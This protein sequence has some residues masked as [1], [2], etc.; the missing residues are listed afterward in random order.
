MKAAGGKQR[1]GIMAFIAIAS[2]L[3]SYGCTQRHS[4][5]P[6]ADIR[7]LANIALAKQAS[8][9]LPKVP[10]GNQPCQSLSQDEQKQIE[11]QAQGYAMPV[12]GKPER[13][14]ANLPFDNACIYHDFSVGYMS[15]G[16]YVFNRDGNHSTEH[17]DPS[18]LP[19]AFYGKQDGVWFKK[20]GY[21]V[22]V[23]GRHRLQEP[24]AKAIAAKL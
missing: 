15:Q 24:V 6:R 2:L 9:N 11:M 20:N 12:P 3:P 7:S 10:F 18:D 22:N 1:G 23:E 16:D 14:P 8:S 17:A 21:Y 5:T 4:P 19:D 13:A